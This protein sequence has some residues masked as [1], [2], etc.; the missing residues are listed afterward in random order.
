M[1]NS[2]HH[3]MYNEIYEEPAIL[4]RLILDRH[5]EEMH[6]VAMLI[7]ERISEGGDIFLVGS[8]SS[9][10]SCLF[11]RNLFSLKNHLLV[12]VFP[13]SE[14]LNY[15]SSV[16]KRSLIIFVSQSG[17]SADEIEAYNHIKQ[18]DAVTI[19]MVNDVESA[20][21]RVCKFILPV[22]AGE[23]KAVPA[24]K[25]YLAEMLQFYLLSEE[26]SGDYE[27]ET[28][29]DSVLSEIKRILSDE[30]QRSIR[31]AAKM[32]ARADNIYVLGF[33]MDLANAA[34]TAL[35]I[36][37]CANIE[38]EAFPLHE[39]MHGPIRMVNK[40]SAVIIFE[41]ET[42]SNKEILKRVINEANSVGAVSI[43][44]G[45]S[46]DHGAKIH[47]PVAELKSLSVFPEIIPMQLISYYL[48]VYRSLNPDK[49]KGL[50]KV[51]E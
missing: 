23:E 2:H 37:E 6:R 41:P 14:F 34:E 8:G 44:V 49:P 48:A 5:D 38:T 26:L 20:L 19:A 43:L 9:Y 39:F 36:K 42:D 12:N 4:R 22:F 1:D 31:K 16:D 29:K 24:T 50:T 32:I 15:I 17:E 21:A 3:L 35:K 46:D 7:K 40:D 28:N 30:Y 45:G 51:V 33:G 18:N 11:A 25:T 27:L 10:N 13:G 47:L